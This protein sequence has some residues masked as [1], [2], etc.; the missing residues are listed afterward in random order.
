MDRVLAIHRSNFV[1]REA[2][3]DELAQ[4]KTALKLA[5]R[6]TNVIN[7]LIADPDFNEPDLVARLRIRSQQ[8]QDAYDTF[9]DPEVS[10]EKAE[11]VLREV[12]RE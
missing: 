5:I 4:H 1:Y 6:F 8:L 10:D 7:T 3:A 12:F 9:H 11:Q 2:S